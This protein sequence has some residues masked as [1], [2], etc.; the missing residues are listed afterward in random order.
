MNPKTGIAG[1][2]VI[3]IALFFIVPMIAG[4]TTNVCQALESHNVSN[5]AG[6][7]AGGKSG[8]VFGVIN[9]IGQAGAT[10]AA[11]STAEANAHPNTPSVISCTASYWKSL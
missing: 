11:T 2:I 10:G 9:T 7:I 6:S 1:A 3:L 8:P 4:G 5:A